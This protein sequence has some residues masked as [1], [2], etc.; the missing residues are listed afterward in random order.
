LEQAGISKRSKATS[1]WLW[2]L[3]GIGFSMLWPSAAAATKL[4]LQVAQPFV[5]CITRFFIAG[6][7]M[8]LIT[9]GIMRKRLPQKREW[10]QLAIYGLLNITLYLGLYV[11]AMRNVSAGLGSLA[12]ATNPVLINLMAALLFG[13]RIRLF[14]IVS[15]FMCMGG[16]LLAAWPSLQNSHASLN[17][18]LILMGCMVIYSAGT[19]YFSKQNW[20]DLHVL[21]INGWQTLLGGIFLLPLAIAT[22]DP[23][24]NIFNAQL[25]GSVLWLAIPVSI[26]GVQLWLY[27]LRDNA[28]KA[29]FWLFLC[30][31]FGFVIAAI[32][33]HEPLTLYT[34]FGMLLVLTGLYLVQRN[35]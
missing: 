3:T 25:W 12:I 11:L 10:V 24:Q 32:T 35:K 9:H 16:V 14:T 34:L 26:I 22:Y 27:L 13:H 19:I 30:P 7:L 6:I 18:I 5:I 2:F 8:L 33:M 31:V 29:S 23:Q 21:T 20:S 1:G 15:L 17:G 4:G 28:V